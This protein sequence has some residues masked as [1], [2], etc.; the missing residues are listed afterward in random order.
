MFGVVEI[1]AVT[2]EITVRPYTQ[3]EL[4]AIAAYVPPPPP[5]APTRAELLAK[6]AAIQAQIEALPE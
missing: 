1:H 5:P 3:A 2:G 4:D 6:L